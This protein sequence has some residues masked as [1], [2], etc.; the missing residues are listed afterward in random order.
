MLGRISSF[1]GQTSLAVMAAGGGGVPCGGR[2]PVSLMNKN[3]DFL[4][5]GYK[6]SRIPSAATNEV[7]A[8]GTDSKLQKHRF[9]AKSYQLAAGGTATHGGRVGYG[10]Q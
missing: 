3:T 8:G 6:G 1:V 4:P 2:K 9:F 7:A 10:Q 5:D